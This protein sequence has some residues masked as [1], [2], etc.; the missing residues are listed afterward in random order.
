MKQHGVV[1][2]EG[3]FDKGYDPKGI[4][5]ALEE[6]FKLRIT[7]TLTVGGKIDRIDKL[8][9]GTVEIIDYKTGTVPKSRDPARDMQLS[10]YAMT[11]L[12]QKV[13]VSF[14]FFEDQKKVSSTRTKEELEE[15]KKE[16]ERR[17]DEIEKS[18]F[19]PTPGK[20]CDFCEFRLICEAW[21]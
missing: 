17:A 7:P 18:D 13:I 4:P 11:A 5:I 6:P 9:D 3:F 21:N 15:T 12:S 20:H 10:V 14:Y 1:L 2:L 19:H 8:K 16:I